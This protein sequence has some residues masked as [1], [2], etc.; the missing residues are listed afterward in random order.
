LCE[1]KPQ[2]QGHDLARTSCENRRLPMLAYR[3]RERSSFRV[4]DAPIQKPHPRNVRGERNRQFC[5]SSRR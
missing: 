5:C 4:N 1:R 3:K 2:H